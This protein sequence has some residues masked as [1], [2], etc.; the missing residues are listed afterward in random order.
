M[1]DPA[2]DNAADRHYEA[3][4][5]C[6]QCKAELSE[7][8]LLNENGQFCDEACEADHLAPKT[9]AACVQRDYGVA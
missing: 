3:Q 4:G 6:D 7:D 2:I 8:C 5:N 9:L 1:I